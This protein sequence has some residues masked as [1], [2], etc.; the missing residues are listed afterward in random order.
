MMLMQCVQYT[1]HG[2]GHR[3]MAGKAVF[4]EQRIKHRLCYQV[5]GEHFDDLAIADAVVEVV[6]QLG[7]EGVEGCFFLSVGRVL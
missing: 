3:V 4:I 7:G 1:L 2:L 6:T 5:L